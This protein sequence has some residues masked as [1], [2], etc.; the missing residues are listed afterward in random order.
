MDRSGSFKNKLKAGGVCIGIAVSFKDLAVTETVAGAGLDFVWIDMEHAALSIETVQEHIIAAQLVGITPLV[1]VRWNDPALIK[2]ILDNGAGGVIVPMI[3]SAEEAKQ[4]VMACRYPPDGIRGF[5]P[6]RPSNYGRNFG[7]ELCQAANENVVTVVQIE[8]IQ[9][10][11]NLDGILETPG[12]DAIFIGPQDLS[13]S[14]GLPTQ[15]DHP[16]VVRVME[17]VVDQSCRRGIFAG[18]AV[19]DDPAVVLKWVRRGIKWVLIGA[20]CTL[21][22]SCVDRAVD[23][24]RRGLHASGKSRS[25]VPTAPLTL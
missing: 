21:L 4:A 18:I 13:L 8:H 6:Y 12:L 14:M 23:S 16:D 1:R 22:A 20:D 2:P 7:P 11:D 17:K 10:V 3:R 9:A 24:V 15:V 5:G 19:G 25:N